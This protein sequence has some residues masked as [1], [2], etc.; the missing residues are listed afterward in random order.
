MKKLQDT[1]YMYGTTRVR[2]LENR[3][4]GT[5][6][7]NL[8]CDAKSVGE[9]MNRLGDC[10]IT[11]PEEDAHNTSPEAVSR[12]REE[13]LMRLLRTAFHDVEE[14]V[15]DPA[16][17]SWMRYPYDC[18]NIKMALKCAQRAISPEETAGMM[19]DFGTVPAETVMEAVRAG[20]Y[21]ALPAAFAEGA[22]KASE[23]FLETGDP[24][25]IDAFLDR[26]CFLSMSE[27]AADTGEP[28]LIRWMQAKADLLNAVITLRMIRM[29]RG[30]MGRLFLEDTLL[31][32]GTLAPAFFLDLCGG[33]E[34]KLWAALGANGMPDY[35]QSFVRR[36][37]KTDSGPAAVEKALDDSWLEVVRRDAKTPFGAAVPAGY[38]CGWETAVKN[39]RIVLAAKEAGL[40]GATVRERVR[41]SYV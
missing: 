11:L 8:L 15:P 12:R 34:D 14:S 30:E 7:M 22:K 13:M 31:P 20:S 38:I 41:D 21:D 24:R 1:E 10:G 25:R 23:A 3:I 32:G 27:A 37:G 16:V 26:A 40:S 6:R 5:D 17:F 18:N 33:G 4:P 2:A 19:F 36:A 29:R 39:I 9:V 35:L 28:A